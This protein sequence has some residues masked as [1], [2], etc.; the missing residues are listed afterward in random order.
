MCY[1]NSEVVYKVELLR[2]LL[3]NSKV[4]YKVEI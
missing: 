4:V 3:L 2:S 1:E